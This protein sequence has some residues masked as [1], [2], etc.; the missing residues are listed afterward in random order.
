MYV[1]LCSSCEVEKLYD[2]F[3]SPNPRTNAYDPV[4]CVSGPFIDDALMA[5]LRGSRSWIMFLGHASE[6]RS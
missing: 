3:L 2:H 6:R 1:M 4:A 5:T